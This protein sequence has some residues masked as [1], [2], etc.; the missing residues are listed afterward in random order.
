MTSHQ[1]YLKYKKKY[2]ELKESNINY[3]N[4]PLFL[5][6][7]N[8][9]S[10]NV[11]KI[12][13]INEPTSGIIRNGN[14]ILI[15]RKGGVF[16]INNVENNYQINKIYQFTEKENFKADSTEEGLLGIIDIGEKIYFSYTTKSTKKMDLVVSEFNIDNKIGLVKNKEIFRLSFDYDYHHGGHLEKDSANNI[17]LGI[18]DGG[19]QGDPYNHAQDPTNYMGKIIKINPKNLNISIIAMGLRNPWMFTIDP[20]D[21]IWIGDVGWD[22]CET[23]KVINN[24]N[25]TY[26]F[27]WNYYEGSI[28]VKSPEKNIDF[29]HHIF[30]YPNSEKYGNCVIGGYHF[31]N[32]G[33][34]IFGDLSGIIRAIK[35]FNDGKW[36]QV[37]YLKITDDI[38]IYGFLS[39]YKN[40]FVITNKSIYQLFIN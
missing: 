16:L 14:M 10:F 28:L 34:Y 30:E 11:K 20:K 18:G 22:T 24:L 5:I 32:L 29:D 37:A 39:D 26:N 38:K 31:E 12:L 19:P 1:K 2:L 6:S 27:G 7:D 8:E 3:K 21:R 36:K 35:K 25:R 13:N 23:L 40:I 15:T 4:F 33:I 17:Y 9:F